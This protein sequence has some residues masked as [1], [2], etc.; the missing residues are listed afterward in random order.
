[1]EKRVGDV[2]VPIMEFAA[3]AGEATAKDAVAALKTGR[4]YPV[5][6]VLENG[7][8]AG[9]IG[10]KEIL[11]GLDPVMFK[12]DTYGGWTISPDWKE[13]V[14]FTGHF[15]ERC[16]AL[17]ERPVK[18]IMV[19]V[20]RRLKAQDSIVKAAHIILSIG[21]E[22]VPVWEE[23]RLVGMVGMKEIFAEMV[24]ELDSGGGGSRGKV[25]FADQ[26]RRKARVTTTT[27]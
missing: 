15:Q 11:R 17:A 22:P 13:P 6:L 25:I 2:M 10:L 5:V 23:D 9:M 21:Q 18:E 20:P 8:V 7:K 3:V 24:R 19:P 4:G 16:A 14:L 26:Y 12:K 27:G 1:M